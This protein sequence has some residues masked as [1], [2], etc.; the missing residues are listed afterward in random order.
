MESSKSKL[1]TCIPRNKRFREHGVK[2]AVKIQA[3]ARAKAQEQ[4]KAR[5]KA[6]AQAE[7]VMWLYG[8]NMTKKE[9]WSIFICIYSQGTTRTYLQSLD[10]IKKNIRG[11]VLKG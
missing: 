3:K 1:F 6:K 5:A 10:E 11:D 4:T 2:E 7:A 8:H 9:T